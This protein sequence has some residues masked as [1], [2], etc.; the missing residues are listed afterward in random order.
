MKKIYDIII[1]NRDTQQ[2][3]ALSDEEKLDFI[4]HLYDYLCG[5]QLS[6]MNHAQR[7]LYLA[8]RLED[9]CQ[10]DALP[11]LSEEEEL[12]LALP[13]MKSALEELGAL[14]TAELLGAFI[15]LL[16]VGSVP[17]WK[18]FFDSERKEVIKGL[19]S[20]ISDYPDGVMSG[21]YAAYISKPEIAEEI[22][23]G[24]K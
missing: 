10:A 23:M 17:E 13:E 4:L 2:L 24:I 19:D 21:L 18:W 7:T 1:S 20:K 5:L 16:P 15:S 3:L 12:F 8:M 14:K 6:E 9:T 22:L 11:S